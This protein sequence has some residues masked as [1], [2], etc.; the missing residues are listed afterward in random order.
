MI[1][2]NNIY[3]GDCYDLIK[4]IPDKSVDLVYT[5]IPYQF[6]SSGG[7]GALG[8]KNRPYNKDIIVSDDKRAKLKEEA[9]RLLNIMN[10]TKDK[11]EYQKAHVQ[12]GKILTDID[13]ADIN[14][15]IDYKII[16]EL[17]R[18]MKYIYIYMV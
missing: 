6:Q 2:P 5:D 9:E 18:V 14:T 4:Q 8:T 13:T 7:G 3:Y 17:N 10:T 15:G 16:D 1:Q 11:D 12:R